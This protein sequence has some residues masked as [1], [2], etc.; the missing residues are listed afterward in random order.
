MFICMP[1]SGP[2]MLRHV[3]EHV[4]E[5]N[6]WSL[7]VAKYVYI[8]IYTHICIYLSFTYRPLS[9]DAAPRGRARNRDESVVAGR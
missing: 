5:T 1:L 6:P 4:T 8:H 7:G 3:D 9:T 2:Q